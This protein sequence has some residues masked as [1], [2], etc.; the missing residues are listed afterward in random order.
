MT[1]DDLKTL[2]CTMQPAPRFQDA[3]AK[4]SP[5]STEDLELIKKWCRDAQTHMQTLTEA[6]RLLSSK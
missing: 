2:K 6:I 4:R 1:L 5:Q 3:G